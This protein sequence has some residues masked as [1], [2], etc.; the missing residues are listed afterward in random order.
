MGEWRPG[1]MDRLVTRPFLA[2]SEAKRDGFDGG[3]AQC[4]A[5]QVACRK[6][7]EE[8][9]ITIYGIGSTV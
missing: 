7:N 9:G 6:L 4:L 2:I 1:S 5:E 3:W 8:D